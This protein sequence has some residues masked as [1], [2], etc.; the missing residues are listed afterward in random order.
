LFVDGVNVENLSKFRI[1]SPMFNFTTP[2]NG[3]FDLHSANSSSVSDGFF[4][5]LKPFPSG[6]HEV[7]WSG[8]L[9]GPAD[10]SPQNQPEDVT[11]HLTVK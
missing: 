4:V 1:D 6:T 11:Y 2:Q 10:I 3:L 5:M 9:G 8:I 7:H